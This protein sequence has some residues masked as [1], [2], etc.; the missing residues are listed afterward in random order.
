MTGVLHTARISAVEF[1]VSCDK[2]ILFVSPWCYKRVKLQ[3]KIKFCQRLWRVPSRTRPLEMHSKTRRKASPGPR[4]CWLLLSAFSTNS[5]IAYRRENKLV[6][7]VR[8]H[9]QV[10]Q[11]RN[12]CNI[13]TSSTQTVEVHWPHGWCAQLQI[14]WSEFKPWPGTLC[15]VLEKTLHFWQCLSPPRCLNGTGEHARG[16][17]MMD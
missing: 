14:E 17:P 1:V 13:L 2:W 11:A 6:K 9:E 5:S 7:Y 10:L 15:Y 16:S 3:L 4:G 12:G 8:L